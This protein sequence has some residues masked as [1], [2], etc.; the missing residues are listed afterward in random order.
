MH[1]VEYILKDFNNSV[2]FLNK[3]GIIFLDDV[4]PISKN[5]Q[6]KIPINPIY[7]N[8]ILKYSSPW[9]GDVWKFMYY[10][11]LNFKDK[12]KYTVFSHQNYRG[13]VKICLKEEFTVSESVLS[14]INS[15]D[16]DRDFEN[17]KEIL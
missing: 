4:L 8:G 2:K 6:E 15:Y 3:N 5:E 12:I 7:E 17:Y 9:T 14:T 13:V 11:L 1:Q 16:Y 10:L